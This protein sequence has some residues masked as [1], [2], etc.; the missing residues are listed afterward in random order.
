[1]RQEAH[2]RTYVPVKFPGA[3]DPASYV[4]NPVNAAAVSVST[5]NASPMIQVAP[6]KGRLKRELDTMTW[7]MPPA[8]N[9]CTGG[10]E[11]GGEVVVKVN[12]GTIGKLVRSSV[13]V[14]NVEVAG[15][16]P[17][18]EGGGQNI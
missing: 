16:N 4:V 17:E 7:A 8:V 3:S 14:F 2:V 13:T 10:F 11:P 15:S 6:F 5:G 1:M 18:K 12:Q 9:I